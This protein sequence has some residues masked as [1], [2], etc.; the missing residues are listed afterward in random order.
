MI[1]EQLLAAAARLLK[2]GG[3]LFILSPNAHGISA[4]LLGGRW[5][6][7]GPTD[8]LVM[9]SAGSLVNLAQ[10]KGFK[11]LVLKSRQVAPLFPP[12]DEAKHPLLTK[13]FNELA[14]FSA[15][16]RLVTFFNVGD[17]IFFVGEKTDSPGTR[18]ERN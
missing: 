14:R 2:P 15:L 7:F 1:H 5:W 13:G 17:W 4:W 6:V 9:F 18:T 16:Q 12:Q 8:H 10:L 3:R 11:T